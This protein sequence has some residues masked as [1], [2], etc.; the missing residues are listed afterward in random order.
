MSEPTITNKNL[1]PSQQA[2]P[3]GKGPVLPPPGPVIAVIPWDDIEARPLRAPSVTNLFPVNPNLCLYFGNR[4][5][6]AQE[7]TMR[8][9]QLL[10]MGFIPAKPE[11]VY[12]VNPENGKR[13]PCPTSLC[14]DGR[15]MNGDTILL[16]IGR[17]EY[18]GALKWNAESAARRVRR[19]GT[20]TTTPG[21]TNVKADGGRGSS[22]SAFTGL[23]QR[24]KTHEG[25]TGIVQAYVPPI[26]ESDLRTAD[27][28]GI[29]A[30][31]N[32]ADTESVNRAL[33]EKPPET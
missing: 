2:A 15:I 3:G 20:V 27:N 7:S 32:L 4:A 8:Y 33:R 24:V 19:F 28:S 21:G 13:M 22:G 6:G 16:K 26:V 23:P 12:W 1:P 9:D 18:V 25:R 31:V 30:T 10:S 11:D 5:V 14:R 29:P 17:R